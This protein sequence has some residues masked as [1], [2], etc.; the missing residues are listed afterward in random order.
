VA[1]TSTDS[2]GYIAVEG[3]SIMSNPLQVIEDHIQEF[4]TKGGELLA[5][6]REAL[7]VIKWLGTQP[8]TL[9]NLNKRA[10]LQRFEVEAKEAYY[11]WNDEMSRVRGII[12]AVNMV[13][14][15][16]WKPLGAPP[17]AAVGVVAVTASLAA[18]AMT[19]IIA[20]AANLDR[21]L[22]ALEMG[23]PPEAVEAAAKSAGFGFG[24][25]FGGLGTGGL[26][27]LGAVAFVVLK[28]GFGK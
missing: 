19:A 4:S 13:P 17:L 8:E 7:G 16:E 15:I 3:G 24:G 22:D 23:I 1:D 11:E 14:G 18:I 5:M 10:E 25:F 2:R 21:Q 27:A 6:R 28:G 12:R 9:D 26:L 20:K